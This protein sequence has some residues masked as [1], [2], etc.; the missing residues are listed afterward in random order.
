M[1]VSLHPL[2]RGGGARRGCRREGRRESFEKN[3]TREIACVVAAGEPAAETRDES[4][5]Y[6]AILTMKSL[7]LAQDER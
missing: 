6:R 2:S 5:G 7:I 1:V 4:R 3:G